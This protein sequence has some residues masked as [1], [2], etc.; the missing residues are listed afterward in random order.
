MGGPSLRSG[1]RLRAPATLTPAERLKL[2]FAGWRVD[3]RLAHPQP[4]DWLPPDDVRCDD[5][6]HIGERH[7]TVPHPFRVNDNI[8]AMLALVK[9]SRLI[10]S[11]LTL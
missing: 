7:A 3:T 6:I 4:L 9:A 8:G 10:G 2:V 11:N 5:L 1:F